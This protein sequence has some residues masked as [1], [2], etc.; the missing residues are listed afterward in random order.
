M[1]EKSPLRKAL[2]RRRRELS[3]DRRAAL[4]SSLID[5]ACALARNHRAVAA[6]WPLPTEPAGEGLP[7]ALNEV[8][9]EVWLPVTGPTRI[10]SWA[11]Y[12]GSASSS[13]LGIKEPTGA[14]RGLETLDDCDLIFV[15]TVGVSP[16][17][18]RL[19]RG[20]GY[21]DATLAATRRPDQLTVT[22]VYP[23]EVVDFAAE[24]HDVAVARIIRARDPEAA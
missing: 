23:W 14:T 6:Y 7:A 4:N 3:S 8:V 9:E 12:D 24:E 19:G 11:R 20:G 10:M 5:A 21:Y 17:G 22:L 15:P 1:E 2:L 18:I 13:S 16:S